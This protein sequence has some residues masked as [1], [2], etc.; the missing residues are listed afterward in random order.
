[1]SNDPVA[2]IDARIAELEEG[3]R[4]TNEQIEELRSSI[5]GTHEEIAR[6]QAA[7]AVIEGR[8]PAVQ[9]RP[10]QRPR[11]TRSRGPSVSEDRVLSLIAEHPD[12]MTKKQIA[13]AL[14]VVVATADARIKSLLKADRIREAGERRPA[15]GVG[16]ASKV[17][18]A[19]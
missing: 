18:A 10:S 13:E 3:I 2:A 15:G 7:K 8:A 6:L 17:Y 9:Q 4:P 11:G 12:G 5:Q 19:N 16:R 14:G 1:M